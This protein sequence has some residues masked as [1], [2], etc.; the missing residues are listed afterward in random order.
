MSRFGTERA[1]LDRNEASKRSI[2]AHRLPVSLPVP[3]APRP[4]RVPPAPFLAQ[5]MDA[6]HSMASLPLSRDGL[7]SQRYRSTEASDVKRVPMGYRKS[8]LA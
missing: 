3:R 7:A 2:S 4:L 5:L 1:K 6:P 8:V